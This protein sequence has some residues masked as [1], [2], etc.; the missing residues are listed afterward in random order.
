MTEPEPIPREH[1][2]TAD[3]GARIEPLRD[4]IEAEAELPAAV[5]ADRYEMARLERLA[6]IA[7]AL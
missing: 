6:R 4:Y 2:L 5:A 7:R 3:D 1:D